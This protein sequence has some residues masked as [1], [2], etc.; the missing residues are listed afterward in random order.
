MFICGDQNAVEDVKLILVG[1][2]VDLEDQRQVSLKRGEK[3]GFVLKID[4]SYVKF[5]QLARQHRIHFFETS[6]WENISITSSFT[7]LATSILNV[8]Q[9]V[10]IVCAPSLT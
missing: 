10:C 2:K 4:I 9:I 8:S 6:A 7:S 1:N 3:V 5:E